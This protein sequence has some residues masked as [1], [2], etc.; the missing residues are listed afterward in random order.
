MMKKVLLPWLRKRF[1][2]LAIG[3]LVAAFIAGCASTPVASI[4]PAQQ[5]QI[6]AN[7]QTQQ[8]QECLVYSASQKIIQQK[9][10]T[11]PIAEATILYGAS[12]QA[13]KYCTTVFTNTTT[14]STLLTKALATIA[15]QA[16]INYAI[17][18]GGAK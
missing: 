14:Q 16:G 2:K 8:Y 7:Q 3:G 6:L 13:T 12:I 11:L 10:A 4:T 17:Q 15:A 9:V 18:A 1:P 5:A